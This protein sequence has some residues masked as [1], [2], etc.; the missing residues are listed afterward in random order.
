MKIYCKIKSLSPRQSRQLARQ[1]RTRIKR[2][3]E[4]PRG[5]TR[6]R[7]KDENPT[8][9]RTPVVFRASVYITARVFISAA[10]SFPKIQIF[11]SVHATPLGGGGRESAP[12]RARGREKRGERSVTFLEFV[13]F[14][15]PPPPVSSSSRSSSSSSS[16][17][18]PPAAYIPG[19]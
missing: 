7:E 8:H 13:F 5:G 12:D 10:L 19:L 17:M 11:T 2:R 18:G 9:A 3:D 16:S 1:K 15:P 4:D 14:S 6:E